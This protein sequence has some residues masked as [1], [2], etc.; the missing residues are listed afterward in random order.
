MNLHAILERFNPS[1]SLYIINL[2]LGPISELFAGLHVPDN[3]RLIERVI[4]M[5]SLSSTPPFLAPLSTSVYSPT[6]CQEPP[7]R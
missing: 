3:G 4:H 7:L 6:I 1:D 2:P 5:H